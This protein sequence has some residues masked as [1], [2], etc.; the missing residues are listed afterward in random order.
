MIQMGVYL[1]PHY[2]LKKSYFKT[3][4]SLLLKKPLRLSLLPP[5]PSH[6]RRGTILNGSWVPHKSNGR[7][8]TGFTLRKSGVISSSWFMCRP[9]LLD[10][11]ARQTLEMIPKS[12]ILMFIGQN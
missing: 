7:P 8:R 12:M 5:A 4:H 9:D 3:N 6:G 10:V 1:L 11:P 2:I